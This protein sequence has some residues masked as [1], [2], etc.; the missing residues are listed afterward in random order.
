MKRSHSLIGFPDLSYHRMR[1]I[2][3]QNVKCNAYITIFISAFLFRSVCV[4]LTETSHLCFDLK[5]TVC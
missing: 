2:K 3:I 5:C 4:L 1:W